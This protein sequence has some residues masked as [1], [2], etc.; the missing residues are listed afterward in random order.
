LG[1]PARE[2][3]FAMTHLSRHMY[4]SANPLLFAVGN[5]IVRALLG[6]LALCPATTLACGNDS[7]KTSFSKQTMG[8]YQQLDGNQIIST[9]GADG[10]FADFRK[11][12]ASGLVWPRDSPGNILYTAGLWV[13]G[14][15]VPS[16]SLRTAAMFF[17]S[18]YQPGPLL[19]TFNTLTN[20]D[21]GPV[22]RASDSLYR[23]Y[24]IQRGDTTSPD[25]AITSQTNQSV[26]YY[27]MAY[28]NG[29]GVSHVRGTANTTVGSGVKNFNPAV[30][31]IDET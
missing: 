4:A 1:G 16:D 7:Q 3:R 20:D 18:E 19:E 25:F 8:S 13:V 14:R 27:P 9:I 10:P 21:S 24:K 28:V 6:A 26:A 29:N 11:T 31:E 23:A 2:D 5:F 17:K 15:H 22:S 30:L 12:G